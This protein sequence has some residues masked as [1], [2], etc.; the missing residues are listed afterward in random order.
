M[1]QLKGKSER[2][3]NIKADKGYKEGFVERTQKQYGWQVEIVQKP[4][5]TKGFVPA[6]G[7]WVVETCLPVGRGALGG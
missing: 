3:K 6:G 7:R 2:L 4:E 5:S 1:G